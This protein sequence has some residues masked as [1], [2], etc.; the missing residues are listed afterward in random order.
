LS[1]RSDSR[2]HAA[3]TRCTHPPRGQ[4]QRA[5]TDLHAR[6]RE[7]ARRERPF[8]TRRARA[9][10]ASRAR[11]HSRAPRTVRLPITATPCYGWASAPFATNQGARTHRGSTHREMLGLLGLEHPERRQLP[12]RVHERC[13]HPP[14]RGRT[15]RECV[16]LRAPAQEMPPHEHQFSRTTSSARCGSGTREALRGDGQPAAR[17][18]VASASRLVDTPTRSTPREP[19]EAPPPR[20]LSCHRRQCSG[21]STV[22]GPIRQSASVERGL[23]QSGQSP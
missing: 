4:R 11:R 21:A 8:S 16:N 9:H 18:H 12:H 13:T 10:G 17:P 14:P 5:T 19:V 23:G 22:P 15:R 3:A 6:T 7:A 20:S 1:M 2:F